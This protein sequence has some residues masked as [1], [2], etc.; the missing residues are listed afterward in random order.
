MNITL[1]LKDPACRDM[2]CG[3]G[4]GWGL[5]VA[6]LKLK[7]VA[8]RSLTPLGLWRLPSRNC[9]QKAKQMFT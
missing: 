3:W 6:R 8:T 4:W 7:F 2:E 1:E 9:V 5:T